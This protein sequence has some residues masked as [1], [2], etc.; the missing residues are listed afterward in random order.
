MNVRMPT[1]I[2]T[3]RVNW[4]MML[5]RR[6]PPFM[7]HSMV[8]VASQAVIDTLLMMNCEMSVVKYTAILVKAT[9]RF[10]DRSW[11]LCTS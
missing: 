4:P 10:W 11:P 7:H 6:A 8:T 9:R 3:A 1:A 2:V 5:S